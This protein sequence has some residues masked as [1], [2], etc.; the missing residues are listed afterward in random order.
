MK[1]VGK[2]NDAFFILSVLKKSPKFNIIKKRI[3]EV[4]SLLEIDHLRHKIQTE[5]SS[6]EIQRVALAVAIA[7]K[8]PVLVLDEPMARIDL[9]SEILFEMKLFH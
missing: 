2:R 6:G 5:L 7:P 4:F 8:P 1:R 3:D 9:K